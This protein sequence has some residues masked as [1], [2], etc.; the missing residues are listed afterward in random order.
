MTLHCAHC[1]WWCAVHISFARICIAYALFSSFGPNGKRK[2]RIPIRLCFYIYTTESR[3]IYITFFLVCMQNQIQNV[4]A[5]RGLHMVAACILY[6]LF[7]FW[8]YRKSECIYIGHF[9][10]YAH[11]V[12]TARCFAHCSDDDWKVYHVQMLY[13]AML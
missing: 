12:Y 7:H 4:P 11:T 13:T 6:Y 2:Q 3:C 9:T 10:V 1:M 5:L 8:L